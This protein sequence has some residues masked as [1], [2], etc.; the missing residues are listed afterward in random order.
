MGA[1]NDKSKLTG[2][3]RTFS[4]DHGHPGITQE[5]ICSVWRVD[6]DHTK[7]GGHAMRGKSVR[8]CDGSPRSENR[9]PSR[10]RVRICGT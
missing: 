8:L 5:N 7:I 2:V 6:T 3:L 10:V 4:A 1:G 9:G